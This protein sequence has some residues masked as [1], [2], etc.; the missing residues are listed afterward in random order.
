V[1]DRIAWIL[2]LKSLADASLIRTIAFAPDV[3]AGA[4]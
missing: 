2:R 4:V 1:R 3:K